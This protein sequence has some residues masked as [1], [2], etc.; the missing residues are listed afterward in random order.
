MWGALA[1]I[2]GAILGTLGLNYAVDSYN[3]YSAEQKQAEQNAKIG[4]VILAAV[5]VFVG[6]KIITKK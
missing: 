4:K 6:Y 2:G 3:E 1:K 5:V